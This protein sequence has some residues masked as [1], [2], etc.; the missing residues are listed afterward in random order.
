MGFEVR[1]T[2]AT[3]WRRVRVYLWIVLAVALVSVLVHRF[4]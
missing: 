1:M 3:G 2:P 4:L